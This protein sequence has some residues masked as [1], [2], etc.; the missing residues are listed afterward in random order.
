MAAV[1]V[2]AAAAAVVDAA[3]AVTATV[4]SSVPLGL[5]AT[6]AVAGAAVGSSCPPGWHGG[7][8]P[9]GLPASWRSSPLRRQL[10]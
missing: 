10:P 5:A 3:A 1:A 4:A 6:V 8:W 9:V 7:H 2:A